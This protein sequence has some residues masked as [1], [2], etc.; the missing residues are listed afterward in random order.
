MTVAPRLQPRE[1]TAPQLVNVLHSPKRVR[2]KFGGRTI[3]DSRNVL[4]LR[5]NHFLPIYFFPPSAVD[6]SVLKPSLHREPHPVGGE[7]AYW[8]IDSGD[9]RSANAAWSFVSPPDENLAPLAGRIA[10]TWKAVDQ[11]FE[12]EEEVFVHARDPYA[13]IDVLQSSSHLQIWFDGEPIADSHRPV[14]LFETHLPTRFYL[15]A[16][17][18]RLERLTASVTT[19]RCPYKGIASYWSGLLSDGSVRPHIAWSYRD[20]IEEMPKIKGLIAF[21]PQAVDR[22]HLDGEPVA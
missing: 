8:D 2:V 22:I 7:T 1:A 21:Y 17:D 3:A 15:P 18:I 5:S 13:R 11:W 19:T 20:P 10:F 4:V 6:P 12:E 14:L 9:R 16:E